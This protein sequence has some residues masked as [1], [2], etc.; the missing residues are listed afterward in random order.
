MT[1]DPVAFLLQFLA[2]LTLFAVLA[3]TWAGVTYP[4]ERAKARIPNFAKIHPR[5][6]NR[7]F[8]DPRYEGSVN[9]ELCH[10]EFQKEPIT[11]STV[12]SILGDSEQMEVS[13]TRIDKKGQNWTTTYRMQGHEQ[14]GA[15]LLTLFHKFPDGIILSSI[16]GVYFDPETNL[17]KAHFLSGGNDRCQGGDIEVMGMVERNMIAV[18]QSANTFGLLNPIGRLIEDQE[19]TTQTTFPAWKPGE[20]VS[21]S[22]EICVGRLIGT[23]EPKTEKSFV[24]AIAVDFNALLLSSSN[25][26]EAC[27]SDAI[28]RA[29]VDPA[30]TDKNYAI[31][32]PDA[33][34]EVLFKV[35][36]RCGPGDIFN[37][38]TSGI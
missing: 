14:Q 7:V 11:V 4:S 23:Y 38:L 6:L 17:L 13:A 16:A 22:A 31:F 8:I 2:W 9:L 26:L 24:S 29:N 10:T 15:F 12:P 30:A 1:K 20:Q 32:T 35:H 36:S 28:T 19:Q 34:N 3:V 5:C 25:T 33:W 27:I 21:N 37:P 18:S